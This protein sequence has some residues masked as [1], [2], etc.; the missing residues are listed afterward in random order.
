MLLLLILCD[1]SLQLLVI[2]TSEEKKRRN[3][4]GK[5][6]GGETGKWLAHCTPENIP[7]FS[8]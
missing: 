7:G 4:W 3:I 6:E 5:E 1:E 8:I 2:F